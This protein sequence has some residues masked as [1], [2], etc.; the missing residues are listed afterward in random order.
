MVHA[1]LHRVAESWSGGRDVWRK[2]GLGLMAISGSFAFTI[3]ATVSSHPGEDL[4]LWPAWVFAAIALVGL[5]ILL[6]ALFER[7]RGRG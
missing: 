1:T 3:W 5:G 7:P 2:V 4:A 6:A